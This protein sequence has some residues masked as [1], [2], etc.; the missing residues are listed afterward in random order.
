[1]LIY[2]YCNVDIHNVFQAKVC[3]DNDWSLFL[4]LS[5]LYVA[6]AHATTIYPTCL[7]EVKHCYDPRS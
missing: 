2:T 3:K 7:V 1:M 5:Q 6:D 4:S